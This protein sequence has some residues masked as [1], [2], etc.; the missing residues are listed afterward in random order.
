MA[1]DA[2]GTESGLAYASNG[3]IKPLEECLDTF[4]LAGDKLDTLELNPT[5]PKVENAVIKMLGES[6][7]LIGKTNMATL[8]SKAYGIASRAALQ[9]AAGEMKEPEQQ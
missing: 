7:F 9:K 2:S 5:G 4:W 1:D 6:P 3:K 8:L